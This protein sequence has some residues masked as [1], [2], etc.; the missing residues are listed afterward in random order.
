MNLE[1]VWNIAF[2]KK[3]PKKK[4]FSLDE[5]ILRSKESGHKKS[6]FE[7]NFAFLAKVK[8]DDCF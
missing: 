5:G 8:R 2:I 4:I 7:V 3:K 1:R 6:F